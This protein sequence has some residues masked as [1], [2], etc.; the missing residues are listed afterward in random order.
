MLYMDAVKKLLDVRFGHGLMVAN[1]ADR[2][3]AVLT[4][5][6]LYRSSFIVYTLIPPPPLNIL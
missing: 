5:L 1:A 2:T 6:N 3:P 4:L